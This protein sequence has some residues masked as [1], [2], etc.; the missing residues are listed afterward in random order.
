[1]T[2][3][4]NIVVENGVEHKEAKAK[5]ERVFVEGGSQFKY[6]DKWYL[7]KLPNREV[8][9]AANR[10]RN[11]RVRYWMDEGAPSYSEIELYVEKNRAK[12]PLQYYIQTE[13]VE[14]DE[15]GKEEITYPK[16]KVT[17]DQLEIIEKM[18]KQKAKIKDIMKALKLNPDKQ[19]ILAFQGTSEQIIYKDTAEVMAG[20]DEDAFVLSRIVFLAD[21]EEPF[22]KSFEEAQDDEELLDFALN[23]YNELQKEMDKKKS[24]N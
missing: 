6:K 5:F 18:N 24:V 23:E 2:E 7:I 8:E 13:T 4:E 12:F 14:K 9:R 11:A 15:N 16:V 21:T 1:M 19:E 3:N 22:W 10:F 20:V 17:L